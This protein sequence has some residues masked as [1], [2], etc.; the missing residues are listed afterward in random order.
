MARENTRYMSVN[1]TK[2][3]HTRLVALAEKC[4]ITVNGMVRLFAE[5]GMPADVERMIERT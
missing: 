3:Q 5:R 1:L 2:D 4:G